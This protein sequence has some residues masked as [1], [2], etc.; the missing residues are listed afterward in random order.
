MPHKSPHPWSF[1]QVFLMSKS[2]GP[3]KVLEGQVAMTGVPDEQ[4]LISKPYRLYKRRFTGLFGMVG[5]AQSISASLI[6]KIS[7]QFILNVAIA[8]G[9]S[10]FG[11]IAL[12]SEYLLAY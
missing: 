9:G 6:N 8:L 11:P 2:D 3:N 1:S 5:C 10:W 12:Q 7:H 4:G